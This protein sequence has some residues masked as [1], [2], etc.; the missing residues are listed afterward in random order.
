VS[1]RRPPQHANCLRAAPSGNWHAAAKSGQFEN[2]ESGQIQKL[3]TDP[4]DHIP[5]RIECC[6][7][8]AF[9]CKRSS[10]FLSFPCLE[11]IYHFPQH[12][13]RKNSG[14]REN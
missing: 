6:R 5:G 10:I 3:V 12:L 7:I 8:R 13:T 9:L 14:Q 4:P 2:H 1:A 11:R